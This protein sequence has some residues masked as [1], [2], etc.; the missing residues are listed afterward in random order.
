[1]VSS[2]SIEVIAV[3]LFPSVARLPRM[4]VSNLEPKLNRL[5]HI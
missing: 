4:A 2:W 3:A 5:R 1:M